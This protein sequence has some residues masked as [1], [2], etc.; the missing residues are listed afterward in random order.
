ML[1][2]RDA[3]SRHSAAVDRA[4]PARELFQAQRI[5]LAGIVHTEKAAGDSRDDFGLAAHDPAGGVRRRKA[6]ER[7][8][9]SEGT[10]DLSWPNLLVLE[11]LWSNLLNHCRWR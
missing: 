10:D 8:R 2:A 4:L 3:Q 11:H 1:D 6:V 7:Q 5:A 9:F